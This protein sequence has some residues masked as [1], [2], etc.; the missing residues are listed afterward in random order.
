MYLLFYMPGVHGYVCVYECQSESLH[1][2][3]LHYD[4]A[5]PF[6]VVVDDIFAAEIGGERV[7]SEVDREEIIR[8]AD[9]RRFYLLLLPL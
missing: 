5:P 8:G 7:G 1:I 2:A 6:F 3:A 9:W 4:K